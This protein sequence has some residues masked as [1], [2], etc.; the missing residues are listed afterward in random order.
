MRHALT[1]STL[2][3]KRVDAPAPPGWF[4]RVFKFTTDTAGAVKALANLHAE[5][6]APPKERIEATLKKY[7]VSDGQA[8]RSV[9]VA[10][11]TDALT[12]VLHQDTEAIAAGKAQVEQLAASLGLT[13]ED[14]RDAAVIATITRVRTAIKEAISDGV[15]TDEERLQVHSLGSALGMTKTEVD[16][17]AKKEIEPFLQGA[18]EAALADRRFSPAEEETLKRLASAL[19]TDFTIEPA[20]REAVRR[21]RLMWEIE[22]GHLPEIAVPIKLQRKEICHYSCYCSWRE[23]RSRTVRINYQGPTARIRIMK[24]VYWRVGSIAPQ[25]VTETNLVEVAR[26]TLYVTNKRVILDGETGNK[27]VTWRS[28]FGQEV[29]SDAIKLDRSS[30]R[31]PYLFI[32]PDEIE[33]ASTI[34]AGA[35]A[36]S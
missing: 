23:H 19:G 32:P 15:Y 12:R 26:G 2:F 36:A 9:L 20:E 17:L 33:M 30:G 29:F 14:L 8:S 35:L 10:L 21:Y 5:E 25:R 18:L 4:S 11:C 27:A 6:K 16:D 22:N 24:G 34:I 13:E 28:V 31:D 3:P 7:G 1:T